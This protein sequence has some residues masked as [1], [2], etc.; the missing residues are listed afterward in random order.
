MHAWLGEAG[1]TRSPVAECRHVSM[2]ARAPT[3]SQKGRGGCSITIALP[4]LCLMRM[5]VVL[6]WG[7]YRPFWPE[8]DCLKPDSSGQA[9]GFVRKTSGCAVC[10][11]SSL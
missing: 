8:F 7:R 1:I 3:L 10:S 5:K 9:R 6:A 4:L 2:S 11:N